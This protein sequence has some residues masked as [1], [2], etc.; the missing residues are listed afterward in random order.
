MNSQTFPMTNSRSGDVGIGGD[1]STY[2]LN[3]KL[4]VRGPWAAPNAAGAY[5]GVFVA[6]TDALAADK[7]G[8]ISLGGV[9]D[10]AGSYTRYA[11]IGGYKNNATSGDYGGYMSFYTRPNSSAP[12]ER[13]RIDGLPFAAGGLSPENA[14]SLGHFRG[15]RFNYNGTI[16]NTAAINAYVN[17]GRNTISLKAGSKSSAFT[18]FWYISNQSGQGKYINLG[19]T[20]NT[21]F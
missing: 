3:P 5:G 21:L 13:M 14:L 16:L 8:T 6:S 18:G 2:S 19:G 17:R 15:I 9:Y 11:A 20:Y 10:G 7:G 12:V 4:L 1:P